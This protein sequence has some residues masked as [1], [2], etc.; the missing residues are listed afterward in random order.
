MVEKEWYHHWSLWYHHVFLLGSELTDL[1]FHNLASL[2]SLISTPLLNSSL[3]SQN[4]WFFVSN[5]LARSGNSPTLYSLSSIDCN[6]SVTSCFPAKSVECF[7]QKLYW[8]CFQYML[9]FSYTRFFKFLLKHGRKGI[10]LLNESFCF[11][12]VFKNRDYQSDSQFHLVLIEWEKFD[13]MFQW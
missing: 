4:P 12:F 6:I 10:S 8:L 5:A 13:W 9:Q 11:W 1:F 2:R 7:L 3:C